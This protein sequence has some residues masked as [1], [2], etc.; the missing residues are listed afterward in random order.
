MQFVKSPVAKA[1]KANA[2]NIID[3][4]SILSPMDLSLSNSTKV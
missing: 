3:L 2:L 4:D 1:A